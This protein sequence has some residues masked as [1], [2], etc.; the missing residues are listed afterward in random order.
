LTSEPAVRAAYDELTASARTSIG[1]L[2]GVLIQPMLTGGAEILI[3]LSQDPMFG[4]L[5]A[6]GLGGIHVELFR[7]VAF[8]MAPLTDRDADEM[9]RSI[10]G[11]RL[12]EGYRNQPAVDLRAIR[13]VL[14]KISY[15]GS[16]IPELVELEF[17][18]VIALGAGRGCQIVDVRARV[19]PS[20][21]QL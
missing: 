19:A 21:S 20:R 11:F 3:G 17:N 9:I 4:P 1:E 7:D 10:R 15:L 5:V 8:R 2:A 13:D 16:E 6:F 12:L 18:P 14:S